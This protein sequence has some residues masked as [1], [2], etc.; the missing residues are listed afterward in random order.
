MGIGWGCLVLEFSGFRD[1]CAKHV[2]SGVLEALLTEF[3][4]EINSS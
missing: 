2:F 4:H 3:L 1:S